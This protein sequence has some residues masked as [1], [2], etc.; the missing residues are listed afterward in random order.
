MGRDRAMS[1]A[2]QLQHDAGLILSTLQVLGQ[3]VTSLNRMSSEV[4]WVAFDH[5][6]F[7]DGSRP[8]GG[9]VS[10]SPTGGS[11]HG[12]HGVVV[13]AEYPGCSWTPAVVLMQ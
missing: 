11:L 1:A 4:M 13:S 6:P 10:S 12:C 2:L 9:A 8:V 5:E 3:L 7:S